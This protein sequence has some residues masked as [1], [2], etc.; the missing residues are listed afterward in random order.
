MKHRRLTAFAVLLALGGY[1]FVNAAPLGTAFT[2]QGALK[3]DGVP[4][5]GAHDFV[6]RLYDDPAAGTQVGADVAVDALV[7]EDGLFTAELDFNSGIFTGAALWL[8]VSVRDTDLGGAY[9]SLSPRQPLNAAPYA[10]YALDGPG[11]AGHWAELNGAIYNTNSGR[12]GVGTSNPQ[13]N[14]HVFDLLPASPD[15]P[16]ATFGLQ[17]SQAVIPTP[18]TEWFYFAVGGTAPTVGSGTRMIREAG[19]ELHFQTQAG[20]YSGVT[21]TQMMLDADGKV[22]IGTSDPVAMVEVLADSGVHGI[23]STTS[24]IPISAFRTSTT[25]SWPAMH[26][27]CNSESADA[28]AIR[29]YIMST[30]PGSG[31]VAV[32]GV[33]NGTGGA[34]I[35]VSGYQAGDGWGVYGFAPGGRGVYGKSTNGVGVYGY[36]DNGYA[37][38][39]N[40]TVA[41]DVLE[42]NGADVAE[43]FPVSG[44]AAAAQPGTVMEIDPDHA[45]QLR[46]ARGAYNRRVA[47]VVSGAGDLPAGT[48]LGNLPGSDDSPAIALSGRVWVRCDASDHAI[49]IGDL[50]TTA[51][52]PGHAMAVREFDRAHGAVIGKAMTPLARGET[53]LVLVLVNLQ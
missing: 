28:S 46:V 31:S 39:F 42:I 5:Q 47:G 48:I 13:F 38:F 15:Q 51:D 36:S 11:S 52:A 3:H 12:V 50:L 22:G 6:F 37:G 20:I 9:T 16:P 2:Y 34:G 45:G 21:S 32:R 30:S 26:A 10:L 25:G 19:T 27:E 14:L 53:G 40:G 7:V 23:R 41:V 8:E 4:A 1:G 29:G 43:K 35:G 17:W 18:P 49:E 44:D 24:A 33:N